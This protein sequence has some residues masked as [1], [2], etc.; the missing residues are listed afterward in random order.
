MVL[1]LKYG[2]ALGAYS[3]R[4]RKRWGETG[5]WI[6]ISA[7]RCIRKMASTWFLIPLMGRFCGMSVDSCSWR[8]SGA[9]KTEVR[10]GIP[11]MPRWSGIVGDLAILTPLTSSSVVAPVEDVAEQVTPSIS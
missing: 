3:K 11:G 4:T 9:G 1:R 8:Q 6:P 5:H 2:V 7:T 10:S